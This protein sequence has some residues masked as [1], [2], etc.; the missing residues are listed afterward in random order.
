[1]VDTIVAISTCVRPALRAILRLSGGRSEALASAVFDAPAQTVLAQMGPY[2]STLGTLHCQGA[3][4]ALPAKLYVF[5]SPKS[6]TR[7]DVFEIHFPGSLP[8]AQMLLEDLL[9]RGA[10]MAEPGEFTRRAFES[11]RVDLAKVEAVLALITSHDRAQAAAAV[12]QIDGS[13]SRAVTELS[14]QLVDLLSLAELAIDFS[15]QDVPAPSEGDLASRADKLALR[16]RDI[17]D[18]SSGSE[19]LSGAVRVA[20]L[21]AANAGK[22]A[23]L[24]ALL[25]HERAIVAPVAGTTRDAVEAHTEIEGIPFI[26]VDLAGRL[27]EGDALQQRSWEIALRES[28]TAQISLLVYD[29]S[30]GFSESDSDI[31]SHLDPDTTLLVANKT[32]IAAPTQPDGVGKTIPFLS[33]SALTGGGIDALR[34]AI[35]DCVRA[36]RHAQETPAFLLSA[37]QRNQLLRAREACRRVAQGCEEGLLTVDMVAVDLQEAIHSLGELTGAAVGESV[38]QR[39]FNQFCIGK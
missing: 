3:S 20:L 6:Y 18:D 13:L 39:I 31:L 25:E 17:I 8:L 16:M 27:D 14:E 21:G 22:S 34:R 10:R 11:G 26:L 35:A 36:G 38:L 23:L 7:E 4:S 5:R 29:A 2:S 37:R 24:N 30:V 1:M 32:D 9:R 19:V 28:E 33:V 15:D 12:R